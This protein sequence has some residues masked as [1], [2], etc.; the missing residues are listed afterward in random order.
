DQNTDP[1][2]VVESESRFKYWLLFYNYVFWSGYFSAE[3]KP[4]KV[5]GKLVSDVANKFHGWRFG[6]IDRLNQKK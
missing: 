2:Q 1:A 5:V 6:M 3:G 4:W